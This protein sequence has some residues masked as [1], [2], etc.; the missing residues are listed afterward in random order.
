MLQLSNTFDCYGY[1]PCGVVVV[2]EL[3]RYGPEYVDDV[4]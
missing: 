4:L 1:G 3:R 2:V